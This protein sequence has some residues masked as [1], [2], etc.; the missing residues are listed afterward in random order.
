M[1][2][3]AQAAALDDMLDTGDK[4]TLGKHGAIVTEATKKTDAALAAAMADPA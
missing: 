1:L 4:A 3:L 2:W